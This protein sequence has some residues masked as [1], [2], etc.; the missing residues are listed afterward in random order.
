[1]ALDPDDLPGIKE[2]DLS[3]LGRCAIC[4]KP[5]LSA[6]V[7][8]MFYRLRVERCIWNLPAIQR[9]AGLAMQ[10]GGA[11]ALAQIMGPDEDMA[12]IMCG[13]MEILVHESCLSGNHEGFGFIL[14]MA[15]ERHAD[16]LKPD[17]GD[18]EAQG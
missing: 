4:K 11:A 2:R 18:D 8:P 16:G 6:G 14:A 12:K 7:G 10:L 3:A 9:Q 5:A 17:E 13:P 15:M 1:M